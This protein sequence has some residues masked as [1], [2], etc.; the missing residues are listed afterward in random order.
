MGAFIDLR[1]AVS[2]S[3]ENRLPESVNSR[4]PLE[5]GRVHLLNFPSIPV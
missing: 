4:W 5:F 1:F 2:D 3:S